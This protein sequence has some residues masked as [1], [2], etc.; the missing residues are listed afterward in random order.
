VYTFEKGIR[1]D[2]FLCSQSGSWLEYDAF[3]KYLRILSTKV[4]NR[5]ITPHALRHTATSLL[6]ADGVPIEVVSRMLG[7]KNSQIT[8]EI[9]FHITQELQKADNDILK[10]AS[11]L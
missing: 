7:H 9:Y 8:K 11:L 1:T 2:L 6:I 4:L 5:K 10:K 3:R